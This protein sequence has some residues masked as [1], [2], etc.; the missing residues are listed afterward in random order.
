MSWP[1]LN[2]E[3][4]QLAASRRTYILR[5]V[6]AVTLFTVA[7]WMF[8]S[9]SVSETDVLGRGEDLFRKLVWLQFCGICLVVPATTC[10]V[11]AE[12]KGRNTLGTLLLTPLGPFSIIFQKLLSRLIPS[13]SFVLLSLP[14]LAVGYSYGGVGDAKL[15]SGVGVLLM[16]TMQIGALSIWMSVLCR[17]PTTALISTYAVFLMTFFSCMWTWP[18][19]FLEFDYLDGQAIL[20]WLVCTGVCFFGAAT[21]ISSRTFQSTHNY[22]MQFQ[23]EVDRFVQDA[24]RLVGDIELLKDKKNKPEFNPVRWRETDRRSL[25]RIRYLLR[26]LFVIELP[27]IFL[28]T[29]VESNVP[30]AH[31]SLRSLLWLGGFLLLGTYGAGLIAGERSRG[32]LKILLTTP[33][34]GRTILLEKASGLRRMIIVVAIPIITLAIIEGVR[35]LPGPEGFQPR[36]MDFIWSTTSIL[37]LV[38]T[39]WFALWTSTR[40]RSQTVASITVLS[41]IGIVLLVPSLIAAVLQVSGVSRNMVELLAIVSPTHIQATISPFAREY[42]N[43]KRLP[44]WIPIVHFLV[45]VGLTIAFRQLSLRN[46]DVVLGRI[47]EGYEIDLS[48]APKEALEAAGQD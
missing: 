36:V 40:I 24:N 29:M 3:L 28:A 32:T 35:Q 43:L 1:L 33:I 13:F 7:C 17:S 18:I 42:F 5:F 46:I 16:T 48:K 23:H 15:V 41:T 19:F 44:T 38:A 2:I 31:T 47:P 11:I 25:G 26:I 39:A 9:T 12:D 30:L 27:L 45:V 6:Y 22:V 8:F 37:W 4:K 14:L 34:E 20:P 21:S 10:G